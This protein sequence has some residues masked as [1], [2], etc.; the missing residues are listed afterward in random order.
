MT[1]MCT[2]EKYKLEKILEENMQS[3]TIKVVVENSVSVRKYLSEHGLSFY[4][5]TGSK[6]IL[7]D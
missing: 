6:K 2:N 5:D 1:C 3:I 4:I 7:F